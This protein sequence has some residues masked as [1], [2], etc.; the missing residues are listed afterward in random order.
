MTQRRAWRDVMD[1]CSSLREGLAVLEPLWSLLIWLCAR[2]FS[3]LF[4]F[5]IHML[6]CRNRS[7]IYPK[8]GGELSPTKGSL[9][10]LLSFSDWSWDFSS[11]VPCLLRCM[12][13]I[14]CYAWRFVECK[15]LMVPHS[16]IILTVCPF[17]HP[18]ELAVRVSKLPNT[19]LLPPGGEKTVTDGTDT[20]KQDKRDLVPIIS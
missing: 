13:L 10:L 16:L 3:L 12:L 6:C 8:G 2:S 5:I 17:Q 15:L 19:A 4:A 20:K 9:Q 11:S 1:V 7:M 18:I 14:K